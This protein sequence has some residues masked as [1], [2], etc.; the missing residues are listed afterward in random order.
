MS[1]RTFALTPVAAAATLALCAES[2]GDFIGVSS[3][4]GFGAPDL[5]VFQFYAN[6]DHPE[7]TLVA[8][9]G[10]P[11]IAPVQ[12]DIFVSGF[13][14]FNDDGPFAG[15]KAADFPGFPI[16]GE[17]DSWV[18]INQFT[19]AD[20]DT[21]YTPDFAGVPTEEQAILG[22]FIEEDGSW[23]DSDPD[24]PEQGMSMIIAQ[25][26]FMYDPAPGE[27]LPP[28]SGFASL[29]GVVQWIP[30]GGTELQFGEF[31]IFAPGPGAIALIALAGVAGHGRRRNRSPSRLSGHP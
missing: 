3:D 11:G 12:L 4:G 18:S 30:A 20:G 8:V 23:F 2:T 26:A 31:Q 29:S 24:T 17:F 6:F 5:L 13:T 10:V 9:G 16:S 15:S 19:F 7:D 27:P 25:F 22:E 14:L 28:P 1:F 21:D